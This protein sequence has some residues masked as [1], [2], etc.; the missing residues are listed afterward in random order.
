MT[1]NER[2]EQLCY[3]CRIGDVEQVEILVSSGID[4][5]RLDEWDYSPLILASL[6]G[7]LNVVKLLL[8]IGAICDRDTFQGERCIYGALN[9]EIRNIL[10][11]YDISKSVNESQPFSAHIH[12]L[13]SARTAVNTKDMLLNNS[14]PVHRWY[15]RSQQVGISIDRSHV[16]LNYDSKIV[17]QLIKFVYLS[18][19]FHVNE[20]DLKPLVQCSEEFGIAS[21]QQLCNEYLELSAQNDI[22]K[23]SKLR[24]KIQFNQSLHARDLLK[25]FVETHVL[26]AK[27]ELGPST[28]IS[29][30]K[31]QLFKLESCP[32]IILRLGNAFYP[33][34]RSM[35]VRSGYFDLM[36]QSSFAEASRYNE[37]T[38]VIFHRD[39]IDPKEDIQV[40]SLTEEI[41]DQRLLEILLRYVYYDETTVPA[42]LGL[43]TLYMSDQLLV[44]KLKTMAAI[45][46]TNDWKSTGYS[47]YEILEAAWVTRVHR[48]ETFVAHE[49]A[50]HF[51]HYVTQPEFKEAVMESANRIQ[52]RQAVDSIELIDDIRFYL[53]R[54]YSIDFEKP[55]HP[56]VDYEKWEI[57]Q[58][59]SDNVIQYNRC[60]QEIEN[61][62]VECGFDA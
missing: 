39:Q 27:I 2:F 51:D 44:D 28:D 50:K 12:R 16:T 21:F 34:H 18:P 17:G 1:E 13:I 29:S 48:L 55:Y 49:F 57:Q 7:H 33:A 22:K 46:I 20:S 11:G 53:T 52:A 45:A 47:L 62:L 42:N 4:V 9:D 31:E 30:V 15:I 35:M 38:D 24:H 43:E 54:V 5:N 56:E 10:L 59:N 36:L 37:F 23:L 60:L 3:A 19:Q 8:K 32:D 40:V 25:E 58:M 14:I 26:G 61:L 41:A 6:C